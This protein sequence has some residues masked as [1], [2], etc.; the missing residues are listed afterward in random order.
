[1]TDPT[2][3]PAE[4]LARIEECKRRVGDMAS[5]G[6]PVRMSIPVDRE[7]DDDL[8][9][10][11]TLNACAA[12]L[13]AA[14]SAPPVVQEGW[15]TVPSQFFI[16]LDSYLRHIESLWDERHQVIAA[17]IR[18]IG[19]RWLSAPPPGAAQQAVGVPAE[20]PTQEPIPMVLH[21]PACGL[22]HIDAPDRLENIV[23]A[24][25]G[26]IVDQLWT[27]PPHRSHLCH[28]C[29]HIWRPADVPTVGVAAV[30]TKGKADSPI[31]A[32]PVGAPQAAPS[33][34]REDADD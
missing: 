8:Y 25:S 19:K 2:T 16:D 34:S 32:A 33:R 27:N 11:D 12:M 17:A 1:M 28:G 9:L 13:A 14:P 29:G 6:R 5:T 22:Q 21:C 26:T 24:S 7:R 30:Q 23:H 15:R 4:L 31:V 18:D 3:Q 20:P 10:V